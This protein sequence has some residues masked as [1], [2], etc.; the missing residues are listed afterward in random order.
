VV[1]EGIDNMGGFNSSSDT[2]TKSEVYRPR[3]CQSYLLWFPHHKP[4]HYIVGV[5]VFGG[6]LNRPHLAQLE[7][8][9][10]GA[11]A[12]PGSVRIW[13]GWGYSLTWLS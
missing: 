8:G 3:S 9:V 1:V 5:R 4:R 2:E 11:T 6:W 7:S 13:G 10:G 12:S